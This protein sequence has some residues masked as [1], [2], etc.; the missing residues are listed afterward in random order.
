MPTISVLITAKNEENFI[1]DCLES[2]SGW[3]DE[4]ILADT[5]STDK[6]L[7]IAKKYPVK[8]YQTPPDGNYKIWRDFLFKKSTTDW[9]FYLDADER[10]TPP[11]CEEIS[12]IVSA[13]TDHAFA[14]PRRNYLLGVE[15]KHGGWAPDYVKRLFRRSNFKGWQGE[16]HEQPLYAGELKLLIQPMIHLQPDTLE[17]MLEKSIKWSTVEARLL[18]EAHHPLI[19]WW[20]ILRMGLTTLWQR[21]IQKQGHLDG[22]EGL[23]LAIYQAYHT[24]IIYMRLWQMQLNNSKPETRN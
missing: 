8:I 7:D 22:V 5:Q 13:T 2:V 20:R 19:V 10:V 15:M 11:L 18:F 23:I 16:L 1:K 12:L 21:L 6:T 24:M 3:A 14:I 4:I 9:I 17:P